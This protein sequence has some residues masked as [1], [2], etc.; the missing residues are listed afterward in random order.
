MVANLALIR[1][2]HPSVQRQVPFHKAISLALMVFR[3]RFRLV[4]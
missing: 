4:S 3:E 1:I 2:P